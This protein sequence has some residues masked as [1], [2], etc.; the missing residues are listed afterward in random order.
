MNNIDDPV[1]TKT[2]ALDRD[3]AIK[4]W[5]RSFVVNTQPVVDPVTFEST[6]VMTMRCK[7]RNIPGLLQEDLRDN[8]DVVMLIGQ[9]VVDLMVGK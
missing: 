9:H 4:D 6:T 1:G 2:E 7:L 8:K 3:L 5:I